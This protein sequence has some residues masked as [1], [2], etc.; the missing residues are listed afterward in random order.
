MPRVGTHDIF[1]Q[2]YRNQLKALL[3]PHGQL[4]QYDEDRAALDLGLHLYERPTSVDS[5]LGHVRVW[6]QLKGIR[7]STLTGDQLRGMDDVPVGSL[8]IEHIRYW[9]AHPEPVYLVVYVE[10]L[11]SFLAEDVRFLVER[12]G[13]LPWLAD[14]APRQETTTLEVARS[15]TL[16]RAL[17]QMPRHR[18]LRLDGPDFRG[19]PLGHRLDPLRC[20]LDTLEPQVFDDLVGRLL[21]AHEFRSQ[22]S[23][24]PTSIVANEI[25]TASAVVGRL[26]LTYEWTTPLATEFGFDPSSD[27][28]IEAPPSFA[29]GD[30]MVVVQSQVKGAPR[31]RRDADRVLG[32]L[33]AEGIEQALVFYNAPDLDG[34]LFGG[35]RRSLAPLL[36]TPQ[37]LGSLAFNVLTATTIYLEFL[38]RLSWRM[39]NYR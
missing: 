30:V 8:R 7:E 14:L 38:D 20:E 17:A 29:H 24:D 23:I 1:E 4:V 32:S 22:R 21:E 13:G 2:T 28:R 18:S 5:L 34:D 33:R 3:A 37:G 12:N 26:Y 10:A 39:L 36:H 15:S 9:F 16:E 27:F 25:G 31:P 11:D 19:R 35:W 6:F